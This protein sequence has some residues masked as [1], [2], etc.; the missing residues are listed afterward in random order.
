MYENQI[1][2]LIK[3]N[4]PND[5][6]NFTLNIINKYCIEKVNESIIKC[7]KCNI[8]NCGVKTITYGNINSKILIISDSVT[9][10]QFNNKKLTLP[11]LDYDGDT[12]KMALEVLNKKINDFYYINA[13][14][15]YPHK[16]E[17]NKIIERNPLKIEKDNCK[18]FID[19]ILDILRP[20]VIIT[21]G[22]VSTNMLLTKKDTIMN[23][24]G[25][26]FKYNNYIVM[27]TFNPSFFRK[28]KNNFDK[29]TMDMYKEF[30]LNDLS[31]AISIAEIDN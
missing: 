25:I 5:P 16:K 1:L 30:F 22:S 15:C 7:N 14:N 9:E 11:L 4:N 10:E 29:K 21:L 23:I 19:K 31:K 6:L 26:V 27:P 2:N 12:L 28:A 17:N 8:S 13:I 3:A 18:Y 24:R 20:K